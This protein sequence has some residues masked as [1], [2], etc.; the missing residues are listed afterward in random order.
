M[1]SKKK[2]AIAG[3]LAVAVTGSALLAG[4]SFGK[5]EEETVETE[6]PVYVDTLSPVMGNIVITGEYVGTVK[7]DQNVTVFP[8]T[9]GE[10]LD[11]FYSVG[12]TVEAG[13]VLLQID[14]RDL[15]YTIAQTQASISSAQ[16]K[17]NYSLGMAENN[18]D[19]YYENLEGG[20]N[21]DLLS[22]EAAVRQAETNVAVAN[23][24]LVSARRQWREAKSGDYVNPV[25]GMEYTDQQIDSLRDSVSLYE[26]QLELA[27]LGLETAEE[28]LRA[29]QKAVSDSE[30]TIQDNIELAKLNTDLSE[31]YISLEQLQQKLGDA[32]VKA[33]ISGVIEQRGVDPHDTVGSS[34]PVFVISNK[35]VMCV[36]FTV[37]ESALEHIRV[38]DAVTVEKNGASCTGTITETSTMVDT[39]G[40]F[41]VKASVENAP[42]DMHT[43]STVKIYADTQKAMNSVLLPISSI[44]FDNG[45]PYVYVYENGTAVKRTISVGIADKENIHVISG[46]T[47]QDQVIGTW[48]PGLADGIKVSLPGE[49]P[50]SDTAPGGDAGSE[51]AKA[52]NEPEVIDGTPDASGSED[53]Q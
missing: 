47:V 29:I 22:A 45:V 13:Q 50:G 44:Y 53:A 14:T 10:V 5:K 8:K 48:S 32:G 3:V 34:S 43:G 26:H 12:D 17:A 36:S 39:T 31:Y 30:T 46:L 37:P 52:E 4:A 2:A 21:A 24:N 28:A 51:A 20:T 33:P 1:T 7:P 49:V 35:D 41:P 11:V 38:G 19:T 6:K 15:E 27:Q 25:T 9:G 18:L 40:L 23:T 16:A 42:F